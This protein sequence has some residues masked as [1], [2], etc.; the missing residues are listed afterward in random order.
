MNAKPAAPSD[1]AIEFRDVSYHI[2]DIPGR[3][4]VSNVS[5]TVSRGETLVLLGETGTG[6]TLAFLIPGIE[7]VR[8]LVVTVSWLECY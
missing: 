6:K 4:I 7:Q 3:A 5:L 2:N 1:V 8:I